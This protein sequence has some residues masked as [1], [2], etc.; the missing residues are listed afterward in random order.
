MHPSHFLAV[1]ALL[2][3]AQGGAPADPAA[4]QLDQYRQLL[5]RQEKLFQLQLDRQDRLH[6]TE[7]DRI[8]TDHAAEVEH[9]AKVYQ[10]NSDYIQTWLALASGLVTFVSLL[11][12]ALLA[13]TAYRLQ[14]FWERVERISA[15]LKSADD[16]LDAADRKFPELTREFETR[17]ATARNEADAIMKEADAHMKEVQATLADYAHRRELFISEYKHALETLVRSDQIN[18]HHI[19]IIH[20]TE[21]SRDKAAKELYKLNKVASAKLFPIWYDCL[22]SDHMRVSEYTK[23]IALRCL[24]DTAESVVQYPDALGVVARIALNGPDP[25]REPAAETLLEL[26]LADP[27]NTTIRDSLRNY[28]NSLADEDELARDIDSALEE[29]RQNSLANPAEP[30]APS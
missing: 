30:P 1:V 11:V 15:E 5:D 7:I 20:G 10:A 18:T 8:K 16:R 17:L 2:A 26:L 21:E 13:I 9:S 29:A 19:E 22:A 6:Q 14:K 23:K 25:L 3:P 24:S 4:A 27:E 12:G 28:R